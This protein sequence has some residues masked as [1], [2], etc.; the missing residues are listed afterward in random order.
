MMEWTE[1]ILTNIRMWEMENYLK[2]NGTKRPE[3]VTEWEFNFGQ[4]VLSTKGF[5]TTTRPMGVE[6]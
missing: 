6:E 2:G 3:N 4:M 1:F 5:G